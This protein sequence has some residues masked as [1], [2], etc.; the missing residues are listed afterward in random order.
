V[1]KKI[2]PMV[3]VW[4]ITYNHELYLK[5]ALESVFSQKLNFDFEVVVGDDCSSDDTRSILKSFENNYPDIIKAVYNQLN[6]GAYDNA[7]NKTM[8]LCIG[9]YVAVLEGDDYWID[10]NKLQK[11]VDF[12]EKNPDYGMVCTDYNRFYQQSGEVKKNCFRLKKYESEVKFDDYIL[13]RSTIGTATVMFRKSL[14]DS[15]VRD[16]PDAIRRSFNVGDTPMWLYFALKSRI[17]VLPDVT[18]VYRILGDS[19][20]HFTSP[21]QHYNFVIKGFEVPDYFISNY[22]V[23]DR[24]KILNEQKKY[25]AGLVYAFKIR[26]KA[27]FNHNFSSIKMLKLAVPLKF[28]FLRIGMESKYFYRIVKTLLKLN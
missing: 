14:Y 26:D 22:N 16:I 20:C 13:D 8:P 5:R 4:M 1:S 7:H 21:H 19:A 17:G 9:K 11:Q 15:Y 24:V 23:S 12:L 25:K 2:F 18:A 10:P 28:W 6:E 3:S 27:L